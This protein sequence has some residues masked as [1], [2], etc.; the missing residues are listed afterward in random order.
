M[1]AI[2]SYCVKCRARSSMTDA[3][4][5]PLRNGRDAMQGKCMICETG[6]YKILPYERATMRN[7]KKAKVDVKQD[8]EEPIPTEILAKSIADLGAAVRGM[9]AT[10]LKREVLIVL[11][12]DMTKQSKRQVAITLNALDQLEE[13]YLKPKKG[14]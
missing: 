9:N 2:E 8:S 10:R 14:K 7:A 1:K 3:V 5:V 13:T 4:I 12:S 11:L 6:M